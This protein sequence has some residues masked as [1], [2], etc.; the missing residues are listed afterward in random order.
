MTTVRILVGSVGLLCIAALA[1]ASLAAGARL[2]RARRPDAGPVPAWN[3][4]KFRYLTDPS[5]VAPEAAPLIRRYRRLWLAA[6]L[7]PIGWIALIPWL[8]G[9]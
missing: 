6:M 5:N 7:S 1:V 4:A 2:E 3:W 8:L 9:W